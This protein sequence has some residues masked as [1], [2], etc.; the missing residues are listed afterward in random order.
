MKNSEFRGWIIN[1]I[2]FGAFIGVTAFSMYINKV[3]IPLLL[4]WWLQV[5][6]I[7]VVF[8]ILIEFIVK[9]SLVKEYSEIRFIISVTALTF[10]FLA[11]VASSSIDVSIDITYGLVFSEFLRNGLHTYY[12]AIEINELK[13]TIEMLE[14]KNEKL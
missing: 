1:L 9:V 5:Y 3:P 11:T 8:Y 6:F 2:G 4:V 13:K 14:G 7:F 10:S 12:D